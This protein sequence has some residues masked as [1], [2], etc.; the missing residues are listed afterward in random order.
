[1]DGYGKFTKEESPAGRQKRG[2]SDYRSGA[3]GRPDR[4]YA[5]EERDGRGYI[6]SKPYRKRA[7]GEDDGEDYFAA[8][9]NLSEFNP[10]VRKRES[11]TLCGLP[12]VGHWRI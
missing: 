2:N 8:R 1:M 5:E 11:Q 4:V 10:N 12:G 9:A 7:D 3:C 6:R